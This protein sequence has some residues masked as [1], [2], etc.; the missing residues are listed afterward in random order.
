MWAPGDHG[1]ET[2]LAAARRPWRGDTVHA[3]TMDPM[4][5]KSLWIEKT[6]R[7]PEHSAWFVQRFRDMAAAGK[8]IIGEA[9]LVDAMAPRGARILDAGCGSG[10][11]GGPLARLGHTVVGI[12]VDPLLIEAAKDDWPEPTWVLGDLAELDLALLGTTER[13]DMIV[14]AG[15][16]MPFLAPSTRQEVLTRLRAVLAPGGRA[17]VGFGAGR[18]YPFE[19]FFADLAATGWEVQSTFRG[20][21]ILPFD[22]ESDFLVAVLAPSVAGRSRGRSAYGGASGTWASHRTAGGEVPDP[23]GGNTLRPMR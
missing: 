21:N 6:E 18:G 23:M 16:V 5:D 9:R 10:R 17:A 14:A 20:W 19:D 22:A 12:D 8:D 11:I 2:R 1:R 4:P 15:N 13:F 3:R 7:D